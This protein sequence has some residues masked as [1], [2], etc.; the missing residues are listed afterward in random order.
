MIDQV[1]SMEVPPEVNHVTE[2][3]R[4]IEKNLKWLLPE[5]GQ[6]PQ[7]RIATR[8]GSVFTQEISSTPRLW[9]A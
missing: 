2:A 1:N 3:V 8:A 6:D 5:L 9:V 4:R 7:D